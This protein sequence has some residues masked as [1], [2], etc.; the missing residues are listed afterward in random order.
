MD[1]NNK[2]AFVICWFGKLPTYFQLWAKTCAYNREFDFLILTDDSMP[3]NLPKNVRYVPFENQTFRERVEQRI[4]KNSSLK[5]AYRLCDFRPLY[6]IILSEELKGYDYWGYCDVD[7]IWGQIS[8]LL[9]VSEIY[10]YDAVFNAGHF[11]LYKNTADMNCMFTKEGALF[12]YKTVVK[13]DA[14]FAFDEI[15]GIQKIA[16]AQ[17]VNARYGIPYVDADSKYMQLRSRLDNVNPDHQAFYWEDGSLFRTKV[18]NKEVYYQEFAYI[19]LQKR[20]L[21]KP[22]NSVLNSDSFWIL[23]DGFSVKE[24]KGVPLLEDIFKKNPY[25]GEDVLIKEEHHYKKKKLIEILNRNPF[26]IYVR[27]RQELA[28]INAGDGTREERTWEKY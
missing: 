13:H 3:S 1:N 2:I 18:E 17:N 12:N 15:T 26:Q 20:K 27:I 11:T 5:H 9:S 23:P 8:H 7:L 19:H 4:I 22:M 21:N 14:I 28:G 10:N 24:Y 25:F 16:K 6:G